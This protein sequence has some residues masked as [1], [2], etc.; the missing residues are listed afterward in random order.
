MLKMKKACEK[1]EL[2]AS[3]SMRMA[4]AVSRSC[5]NSHVVEVELQSLRS[6]EILRGK[7]VGG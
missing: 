3:S 1:R 6:L 2:I 4:V 7:F 5:R